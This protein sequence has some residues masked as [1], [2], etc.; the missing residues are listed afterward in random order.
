[1]ID[2]GTA[3]LGDPADDFAN[4]IHGLG[5]SFLRRMGRFY[6]EIAHTLD[7]ARF[8]AGTLEIQWAINGL[9]SNDLSWLV[10]H[11]GRARDMLPLG[12]A[13]S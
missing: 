6:P 9:R 3:G 4:I 11:I 8:Q 2:F 5:E 10:C 12:A 13:W 1:V 7:R